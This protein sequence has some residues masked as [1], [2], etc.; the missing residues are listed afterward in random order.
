MFGSSLGGAVAI[1]SATKTEFV[2]S[3]D[4]VILQNTFTSIGDMI[5]SLMPML[6]YFKFL[7]TNHWRSVDIVKNIKAPVLFV[8]SLEDELVPPAHMEELMNR[9]IQAK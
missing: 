1:Y 2:N 7:Q 9:A 5:D 6:S 4:G 8:R 3:I